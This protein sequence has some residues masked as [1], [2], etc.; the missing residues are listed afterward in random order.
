LTVHLRPEEL[1][2]PL[3]QA[4]RIVLGMPQ[5]CPNGLS[6]NWLW[7]ELGHRHWE[8]IGQA[9]GRASAGFGPTGAQPTY[10]AFK[11]IALRGGDLGAVSE[12]D[13]L[14]LRSNLTHLSETR[15]ASRHRVACRDR[16]VA[17]VEMVS[18]FVRRQTSGVN[19]SIVRVRIDNPH[20]GLT[21]SARGSAAP[22]RTEAADLGAEEQ[23]IG[24]LT[25]EPCPHLDFN[26][27]GLL[28]FSSFIAAVDR[29][30]W[31]LMGKGKPLTITRER[32]AV[33]HSN[34]EV[35]DDVTVRLLATVDAPRQHRALVTAVSDGRLLAEIMTDKMR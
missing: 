5:L 3:E 22:S 33:F 11:R 6:E 8:L 21:V 32:Q 15:V 35:G 24:S 17:D 2:S 14:D 4:T 9:I 23:E 13:V 30:E 19:R 34:I 29:A 7:K 28:Y 31:H 27:A 10:A 25:I 12:N 26:G 18:V 1:G 20:G 16:L